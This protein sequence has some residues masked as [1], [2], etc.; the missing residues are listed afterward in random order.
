MDDVLIGGTTAFDGAVG[1]LHNAALTGFDLLWPE[2]C[3]QG[4]AM[5]IS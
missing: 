1:N 2:K 5:R 4:G 3:D